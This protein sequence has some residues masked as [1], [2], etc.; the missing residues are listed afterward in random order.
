MDVTKIVVLD[1]TAPS[2][3]ADPGPGPDAGSLAGKVVGIRHDRTWRSFEHVMAAWIPLLEEAGARVVTWCAGNRIG[4][5]GERTRAELDGFA[6]R[7]D[8]AVVGLGN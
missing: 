1:P 8:V 6:D 3:T 2:P 5:E 4:E 7:V